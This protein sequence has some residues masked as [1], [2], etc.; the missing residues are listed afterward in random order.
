MTLNRTTISAVAVSLV[1]LIGSAVTVCAQVRD[2]GQFFSQQAID[3]ANAE[4]SAL[5]Q[6]RG[7]GLVIET[8][9]SVPTE[10]RDAL[11]AQGRTAFF[12]RW[13]AQRF[14]A[15]KMNGVLVIVT[16]DP[17]YINVAAGRSTDIEAFGK[18]DRDRLQQTLAESFRGKEYDRGLLEGVAMVRKTMDARAAGSRSIPESTPPAVMGSERS[19]PSVPATPNAPRRDVEPG[20][21]SMATIILWAVIIGVGLMLI[22]KIFAPR[23]TQQHYDPRYG[24]RQPDDHGQAGGYNQGPMGGGGGGSGFGRGLGGGLLGGL[25]GMWLYDQFFRRDNAAHGNDMTQ[26]SGGAF[27]GGQSHADPNSGMFSGND[28]GDQFS[29]SGGSFGDDGGG[30]DFGGGGDSS[31]GDF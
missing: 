19:A 6:Q 27:G 7:K 18:A 24:G 25:G 20:G 21:I 16:R 11:K 8:Y 10:M 17:A 30:S 4:I 13:S 12:D 1:I 15:D 26:Q 9:P 3:K 23:P 14:A 22:R 2:E 29:S 5:K 31:G 28:A